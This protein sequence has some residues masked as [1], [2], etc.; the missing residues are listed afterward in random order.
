MLVVNGGRFD[1]RW[2]ASTGIMF[3]RSPL[4]SLFVPQK[5]RHFLTRIDAQD[6]VFM[7]DLMTSGKVTPVIGKTFALAQAPEA[8]R[9]WASGHARG[10]AVVIP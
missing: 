6:L 2:L 7:A 4:K 1:K 5:I 10:K 9:Y 8:I 3:V